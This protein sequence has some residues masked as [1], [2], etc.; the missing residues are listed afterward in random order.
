MTP[1]PAVREWTYEEFARLPDDGNRYEVIAGELYVTPPP[2]TPH[3]VVSGRFYLEMAGF[4]MKEHQ[5]GEVL[6]SPLA[7]LFG[8]GDYLEPDIVFLRSDHTQYRT[9]RAIE[10]PPDLIIE[11]LSRS[12][13][14]QDR[15]I[16]RERYAHFGVPEYWIIDP[17]RR[18]VEVYRLQ[19]DA[20][21]PTYV[22]DRLRWQPV[23][24]GPV[25]EL[26]IRELLTNLE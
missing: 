14:S 12:T 20:N 8:E 6:Y 24:G 19:E 21:R 3:Q 18:R 1:Q 2:E 15:G 9:R 4:G 10:G 16:K 7:V 11:I 26:N 23:E 25:L 22:T 5:L 13:A 17:D